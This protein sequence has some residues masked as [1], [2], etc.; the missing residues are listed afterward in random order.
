MT[1]PVLIEETMTH[2]VTKNLPAGDWVATAT[3][4]IKSG[5]PFDGDLIRTTTCEL[6][7]GA[8]WIGGAQDR[9][10][11]PDED[12]V[13]RSLSMNGGTSLPGGGQVSLWCSAQGGG[14]L[15]NQA[16][17]MIMQVGHFF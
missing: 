10:V 8:N 4:N 12:D 1:E 16:Q 14:E 5:S 2:V 13:V 3:A 6:R 9:R 11:I 15:V 7:S 17:I